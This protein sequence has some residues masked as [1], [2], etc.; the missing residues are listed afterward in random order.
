M[1]SLNTFLVALALAMDAFTVSI[2]G[3][4]SLNKPTMRKS[5]LTASYFGFFQFFM[6]ILGW[7]G[8][9]FF[10]GIINAYDHWVAFVLLVLVGGKM[11]FEFF[12]EVEEKSFSLNHKMLL[13][14][15]IATSI[16]AL[17]V[18]LSYAFLHV[19]IIIPSIVIGVVTFI[20]SVVGVCLGKTLKRILKNK[21]ELIG[22]IIL[23]GIGLNILKTHDVF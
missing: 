8:G 20:F 12:T 16:D 22:G 23:I 15:A 6:P 11:V 2:S 21:A 1:I 5:L 9:T 17:G 3:G 7:Y 13:L 19:Q 14:L 18:G 4:A 10:S